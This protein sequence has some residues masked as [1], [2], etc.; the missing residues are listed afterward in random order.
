MKHYILALGLTVL[1]LNSCQTKDEKPT[2]IEGLQDTY[3][4][5]NNT[6]NIM[7]VSP[8]GTAQYTMQPVSAA[9][10]T[11]ASGAN[12][13]PPHGQP[14]HRCDIAVG[15]PL[16]SAPAKAATSAPQELKIDP[17]SVKVAQQ[18]QAKKTAPG[19][20]PPHGQ[21]GHRCDIA[22]GAP[23]NSAPAKT[24]APPV[25]QVQAPQPAP[26]GPKPEVNPAHGEPW[27]DCSI[28]VGQPLS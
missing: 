28:P 16:N 6:Q 22:V 5:Q 11:A 15:A 12:V 10:A 27:H 13:N 23:L 9:E 1:F 14:G 26:T 17:T 3:T 4:S 18:E 24:T 19:T 7:P 21:P 8:N 25:T 20:N 2:Y